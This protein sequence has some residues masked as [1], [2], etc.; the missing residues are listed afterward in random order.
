MDFET[1]K[2]QLQRKWLIKGMKENAKEINWKNN[3]DA[4]TIYTLEMSG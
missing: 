4:A 2:V 1:E 3:R